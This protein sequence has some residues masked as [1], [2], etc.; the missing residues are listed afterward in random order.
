MDY[1]ES[2]EWKTVPWGHPGGLEATQWLLDRS[3]IASGGE[4]L[5]LCCGDGTSASLLASRGYR[6][7]GT[8]RIVPEDSRSRK[9][10][11][12][13][14]LDVSGSLP[15][16]DASFDG[17]LCECSFSLFKEQMGELLT[18]V[19]RVL[20]KGGA[21]MISDLYGCI[22][23]KSHVMGIHRWKDLL[24]KGGF[25][26][27]DM[28]EYIPE[29]RKWAGGYLWHTGQSFPFHACGLGER[30]KLEE[31]GYFLGVWRWDV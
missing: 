8:D 15:F 23:N 10:W 27:A 20:K 2:G 13:V 1:Y 26:L 19:A 9:D 24:R 11:R 30:T 31:L 22:N 7:T 17:V 5:D 14:E 29:L 4:I 16:S 25:T 28:K 3:G 18:E 21:F 6:V 12:F